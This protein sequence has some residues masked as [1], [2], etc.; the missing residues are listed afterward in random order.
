MENNR[1]LQ[2]LRMQSDV[3]GV[4]GSTH[5]PGQSILPGS[6]REIER[7][8]SFRID[9]RLLGRLIRLAPASKFIQAFI[10]LKEATGT[11]IWTI[12]RLLDTP[13]KLIKLLASKKPA[14]AQKMSACILTR[15]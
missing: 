7:A 5:L 10:L 13:I 2:G 9:R 11:D 8:L 14:T 6:P 1:V 3:S 15:E 12:T 4:N